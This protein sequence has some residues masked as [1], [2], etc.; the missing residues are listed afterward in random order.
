MDRYQVAVMDMLGLPVV[1]SVMMTLMLTFRPLC[2]TTM[3]NGMQTFH[4][5]AQVT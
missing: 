4:M 5:F 3:V 1:L 2:V